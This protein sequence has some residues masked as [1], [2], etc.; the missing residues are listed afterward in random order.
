MAVNSSIVQVY[1]HYRGESRSNFLSSLQRFAILQ[2]YRLFQRHSWLYSVNKS[3]V[4]FCNERRR[5]L[6][7]QN[8]SATP[9]NSEF[10]AK[11]LS[12]QQQTCRAAFDQQWCCSTRLRGRWGYSTRSLS[13]ETISWA[14]L[15][16]W[17]PSSTTDSAERRKLLKCFRHPNS[18]MDDLF[19]EKKIKCLPRI[20]ALRVS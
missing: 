9:F 18:E 17:M 15:S 5:K 14:K 13:P 20:P 16:G 19:D 6:G 3:W 7:S 8:D 12:G 4:Q 1:W 10:W 2:L 11:L